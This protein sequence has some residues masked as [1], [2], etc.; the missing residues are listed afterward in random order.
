MAVV[1][2]CKKEESLTYTKKI[3][4]ELIKAIIAKG[5]AQNNGIL[6]FILLFI[7]LTTPFY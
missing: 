3:L 1:R 7:N 4:V 2:S 5:S 6:P